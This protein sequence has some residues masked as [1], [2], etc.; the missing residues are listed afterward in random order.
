TTLIL[1]LLAVSVLGI[2]M[3]YGKNLEGFNTFLFEY[4]PMYNKFRAPSMSLIITQVTIP[5]MAVI[6]LQNL[7][8][9]QNSKEFLKDNFKTILY[10][11]GGLFALLGLMYLAMSYTSPIDAQ[12]LA[13][14]TDE[15]GSDEM[16]RLIVSGL[17]EDRAAMFG[18][19]IIRAFLFALLL[20]GILYLYMKKSLSAVVVIAALTVVTVIEMLVIDSKYLNE[21]NYRSSDELA[22]ENFNRTPADEAIL[23]DKDPNFRVFNS[24]P[25][26]FNEARTSYFHKSIGG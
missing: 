26:A 20:L 23:Q 22:F 21:D 24:A 9:T 7:L 17:K 5:V 6:T 2:L 3:S 11:F 18:S 19:Q 25:D 10:T 14:Y 15:K 1:A 8:F 16:G 4:L 13:A 12:I